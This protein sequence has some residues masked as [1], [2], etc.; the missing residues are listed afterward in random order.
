MFKPSIKRRVMT[1]V[2]DRIKQAQKDHDEKLD[3]LK[4]KHEEEESA[5]TDSAVDSLISVFVKN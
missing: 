1:V 2:N 4:Q 5:L 3:V